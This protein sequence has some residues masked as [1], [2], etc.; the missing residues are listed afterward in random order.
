M[1]QVTS[2]NH[3]DTHLREQHLT[4][5]QHRKCSSLSAWSVAGKVDLTAYLEGIGTQQ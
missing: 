4:A 3:L 2:S 1:L 5:A